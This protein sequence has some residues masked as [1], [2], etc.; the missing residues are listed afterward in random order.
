MSDVKCPYCGEEQEINHDDGYGYSED[1]IHHQGC[2]SCDKTFTFTTAIHFEYHANEAPCLND[3]GD[4]SYK[5]M[6]THPTKYT[7]AHCETCGHERLATEA[8]IIGSWLKSAKSR[9]FIASGLPVTLANKAR[10]EMTESTDNGFP[11]LIE[12][13]V[14]HVKRQSLYGV[15]DFTIR[16]LP[17]V[18]DGDLLDKVKM[19]RFDHEDVSVQISGTD[20]KIKGLIWLCYQNADGMKFLRPAPEFTADRFEVIS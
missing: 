10:F 20:P 9:A 7:K 18:K 8:E 17:D 6:T 19:R 12:K 14:R 15:I 2:G 16:H 1:D 4:H 5:V 3:E 13:T 11:D